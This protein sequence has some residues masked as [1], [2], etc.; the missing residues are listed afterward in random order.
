M[1]PKKS[2]TKKKG[3]S[4]NPK[5]AAEQAAAAA[6]VKDPCFHCG[7]GRKTKGGIWCESCI[8]KAR[9]AARLSG[10]GMFGGKATPEQKE[11]SIRGM[12]ISFGMIEPEPGEFPPPIDPWAEEAA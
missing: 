3:R 10:G 1:A 11:A 12:A 4:G 5:K 6:V 2:T 9:R 7:T 8:T